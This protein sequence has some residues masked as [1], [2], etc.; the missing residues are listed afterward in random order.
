MSNRWHP[1]I[2]AALGAALLFG[3]GT[4]FAK[5]LLDAVSPWLLAG[6]LY[7]GAGVGL[8]VL[9]RAR[10][11][12]PARLAATDARWLAAAIVSGGIAGPVLLMWGLAGTQASTA[13]LLLNAEGVLTA[14]IAWFVF[15]ENFDR[16]IALGMACIIAGAVVLAWPGGGAAERAGGAVLPALAIVGACLAWAVDNNLTRKVSLADAT[17]I[18][19]I[20][21]LAAGVTNLAIAFA[22]GAALPD[23]RPALAGAALGFVSYGLSLVLFVV[24][25]R[26]LGTAR[27]GAYFSTAPFV[28][29]LIAVAFLGEP[30]TFP[31]G[32]AALLM[33]IGVWLHVTER[34][35]HRHS[36]EGMEHEHMHE[37]DEHHQHVHAGPVAP[38]TRHSHRHQHGAMTHSHPHYPDAHHLHPH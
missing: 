14:L 19:M 12:A 11:T 32:I 37:H 23:I 35:E 8:A 20:K 13:S 26:H 6:L 18:A 34:H 24:A 27:T 17:F 36:H 33:G 9:R 28:G 10:G 1:G 5:L 16:R 38:G 30:A 25:L 7:L 3:A 29:A 21:G 15:R 4:P 2:V 22:L 31:L